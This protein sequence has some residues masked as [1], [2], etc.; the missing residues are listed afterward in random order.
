M[1]C[2]DLA[3]RRGSAEAIAGIACLLVETQPQRAVRLFG[4]ATAAAEAME[5]QLNPSSQAQ[6]ERSLAVARSR[7]D[8]EAFAAAWDL[9]RSRPL[10]SAVADALA[11]CP[12]TRSEEHAG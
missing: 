1:L 4:G 5:S 3:D 7:M 11:V 2:R 8:G 10:E 9:G 12:A 6:C